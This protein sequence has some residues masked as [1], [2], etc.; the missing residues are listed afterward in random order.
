MY[1]IA[2]KHEYNPIFKQGFTED[3]KVLFDEAR[4]RKDNEFGTGLLRRCSYCGSM[5]PTD[6]VSAIK[7]GARGEIADLKYGWPHKVY[8]HGVPNPHAGLPCYFSGSSKPQEGYV[9]LH[10][11][12]WAKPDIEAATTHGKFYTVHLQDA[13]PEEKDFIE[14]YLGLRFVFDDSGGVRWQRI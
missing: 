11:T 6:V 1:S 7:A 13:T 12:L 5:H 2:H 8:F 10:D 14:R 4:P 9:K 3:G